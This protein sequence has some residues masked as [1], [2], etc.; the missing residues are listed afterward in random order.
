MNETQPSSLTKVTFLSSS[1]K[2]ASS[3]ILSSVVVL[4]DSGVCIAEA[5]D[6]RGV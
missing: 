6:C 4:A 2:E 3:L 5:S 1:C